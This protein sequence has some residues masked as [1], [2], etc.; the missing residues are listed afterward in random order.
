M[1][2]AQ[3]LMPQ[4][5]HPWTNFCDSTMKILNLPH[6]SC[7]CKEFS[8]SFAFPLETEIKDTVWYTA[9]IN[10]LR[11]GICAYWFSSSSVT[12][13]VFAFCSSKEPTFSLTVGPNQMRDIDSKMI[14]DKLNELSKQQQLMAET[15]TPHMRVYP[16]NGGSGRVYCYPYN[17]GPESKCDDPLPLRP[18][19]TYVCEK[20][21]IK[22]TR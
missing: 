6:Y 3:I 19:M 16:L 15:L 11:Q 10:D 9:T 12:M 18:G 21:E 20:E 8:T 2:D 5:A 4:A 14:E 7:M 17:Q 13:E 22:T 1:A